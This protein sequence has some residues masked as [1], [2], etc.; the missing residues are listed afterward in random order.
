MPDK[1]LIIDDSLTN[2]VLLESLLQSEGIDSTLAYSGKEALKILKTDKPSLILLDIMMPD[3]DGF[4]VL[5]HINKSKSHQDIPVIMITAKDDNESIIRAKNAG[6]K[7]FILKPIDIN[8]VLE[9]VKKLL[10]IN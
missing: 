6:V 3:M 7:D 4:T 10:T 2:N 1:V 9:S 5:E 8:K